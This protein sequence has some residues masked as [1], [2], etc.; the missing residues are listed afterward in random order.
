MLRLLNFC[1]LVPLLAALPP[2]AGATDQPAASDTAL[3]RVAFGVLQKHKT[4]TGD[5][6]YVLVDADG[7]VRYSIS[8]SG[9]VPLDANVGKSVQIVGEFDS[10][11]S[12]EQPLLVAQAIEP[13]TAPPPQ[14]AELRIVASDDQGSLPPLMPIP[15]PES[16]SSRSGITG[17]APSL[18]LEGNGMEESLLDEQG[19][20]DLGEPER[21]LPAPDPWHIAPCGHPE[22]LW[23]QVSALA[24][25]TREMSLPPLVTTSPPGTPQAQAGVLGAAGTQVLFGDG[26]VFTDMRSGTQFRIGGW[27]G[28]RRWVGLEFDY[29]GLQD[30][31]TQ[32]LAVSVGDQILARP[33]L[34]IGPNTLSYD[35]ALVAYPNLLAGTVVI[36]ADSRFQSAGFHLLTNIFCNFGK[37]EARTRELGSCNSGFRMDLLGGYRYIGLDESVT[38]RDY[39]VTT[40]TP[41]T[42]LLG[43]D[44]FSTG[45]DFHGGELGL[46]AKYQR[47]R[48]WTEGLLR[49]ALG[50]TEES[51]AIRGET[52]IIVPPN[53]QNGPATQLVGGLL[54][55]TTNIGDYSHKTFAWAPEVG[56]TGGY[57]LTPHLSV[58]LGYSLV[59][60]SRVIRPNGVIDLGVN[61]TYIPDPTDPNLVPV[62]P[63]R[64]AVAFNDTNYWAQGFHLGLDYRW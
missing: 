34:N 9:D 17:P 53:A 32:F 2:P 18:I 50:R 57:E 41:R 15:S 51:I 62:G 43:I 54:A 58:K 8:P 10:Q 4:N 22:R 30:E 36:D 7:Q 56:L 11:P 6:R 42:G 19:L 61:E 21:L 45:N 28:P 27:L 25:W 16:S 5:D 46:I 13:K 40:V 39:L 24:W 20:L 55:Q 49:V 1:L 59:F 3:L 31:S 14:F 29:T 35:S 64:P 37:P 63:A 60:L 38:I 33:F 52:Q 23:G 26:D 44:Q 47:R 48:W 12:S